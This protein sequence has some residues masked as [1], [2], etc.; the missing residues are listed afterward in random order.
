MCFQ[1]MQ[2]FA[3]DLYLTWP[4]PTK[5]VFVGGQK[6]WN[7]WYLIIQLHH[8]HR[9]ILQVTNCWKSSFWIFCQGFVK[10]Y[11]FCQ[12]YCHDLS[13]ILPWFCQKNFHDFVKD[14]ARICQRYCHDF[15]AVSECNIRLLCS[16][17]PKQ[18]SQQWPAVYCAVKWVW[19]HR[20]YFWLN[21]SNYHHS[22]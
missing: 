8:Q 18:M 12:R 3:Q 17:I 22:K 13:K 20:I 16:T 15:D 4:W 7:V 1:R 11:W 21:T 14:I 19:I 2:Q 6:P 5:R 9:K 10:L